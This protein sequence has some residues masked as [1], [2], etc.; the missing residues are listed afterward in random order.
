MHSMPVAEV[1]GS[2]AGVIAGSVADTVTRAIAREFDVPEAVKNIGA[3]LATSGCHYVAA[4]ATKGVINAVMLDPVGG[5]ANVTATSPT[6]A[7]AHGAWTY[8]NNS[9]PGTKCFPS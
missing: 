6:T 5:V 9:S 8:A 2:I 7:L 4:A 3:S 1:V